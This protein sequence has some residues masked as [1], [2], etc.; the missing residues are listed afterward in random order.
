MHNSSH[1]KEPEANQRA[2]QNPRK[3]HSAVTRPR[4]HVR[5]YRAYQDGATAGS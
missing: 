5:E 3:G 2:N 1:T 4:G